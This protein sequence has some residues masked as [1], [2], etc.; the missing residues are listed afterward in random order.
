MAIV[1]G[2]FLLAIGILLFVVTYQSLGKGWLPFGSNGIRG[3]LEVQRE[4]SPAAFWAVFALYGFASVAVT[5]Y[6]VLILIR[7]CPPLPLR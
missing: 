5:L 1:Q 6:A 2:L 3:R 4:V 7:V